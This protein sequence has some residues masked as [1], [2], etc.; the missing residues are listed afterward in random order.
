VVQRF[1]IHLIAIAAIVQAGCGGQPDPAA[2][3]KGTSL[4]NAPPSAANESLPLVDH[5]EYVH[6]SQF[7]VGTAVTRKKEVSNEHGTVRVTTIVRLAEKTD[8]KVVVET[9]VTVDRLNGQPEENP[10]FTAEFPA[11]FRLPASM[12]LEQ[13]ALPALRAKPI[14][15]E[16]HTAAG[17]EYQAHVFTW[18]ERNETGPMIVKLWR[19]NEIPGRMLRQEIDGPMHHSVEETVEISLPPT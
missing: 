4:Q 15:D 3:A 1:V 2:V 16:T 18:E 17:R 11:K 10:P 12:K 14:G 5:P 6:W 8:D 13:F 9:Q 19:S 7:P